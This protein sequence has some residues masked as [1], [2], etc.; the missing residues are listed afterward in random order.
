MEPITPAEPAG[1]ATEMLQ[2]PDVTAAIFVD[3]SGRRGERLR[4]IA[5]A[6]VALALLL[7]LAFWVAQ[8]VDVFASRT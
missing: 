5:Y 2:P 6:L 4:L 7:I 3:G 8:G 1:G